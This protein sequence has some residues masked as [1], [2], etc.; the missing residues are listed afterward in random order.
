MLY[1]LEFQLKC[2]FVSET[3]LNPSGGSSLC[4]QTSRCTEEHPLQSLEMTF[5]WIVC[6]S[7]TWTV[8]LSWATVT[9]SP[10]PPPKASQLKPQKLYFLLKV[11]VFLARGRCI[12][13]GDSGTQAPSASVACLPVAISGQLADTSYQS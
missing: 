9:N 5:T 11:W 8:G 13:Q 12:P 10:P 1:G 3:L 2:N 7:V 4:T 6:I